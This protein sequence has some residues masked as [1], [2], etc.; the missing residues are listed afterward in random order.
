M[1]L[2]SSQVV[3]KAGMTSQWHVPNQL[4]EMEQCRFEAERGIVCYN[5]HR[6]TGVCVKIVDWYSQGPLAARRI[7]WT[8]EPRSDIAG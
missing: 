1:A 8:L 6:I 2:M 5:I 7:I 4:T 3:G